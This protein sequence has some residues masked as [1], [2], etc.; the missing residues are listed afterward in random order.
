MSDPAEGCDREQSRID[1]E[2]AEWHVRLGELPLSPDE[3]I[4]LAEWLARD[5]RHVQAFETIKQVKACALDLEHLMHRVQSIDVAPI[6]SQHEVVSRRTPRKALLGMAATAAAFVLV[7]E[8]FAALNRQAPTPLPL[9]Y[10]TGTGETRTIRLDDGSKVTL[11]GQSEV[12]VEFS[13]T[14]RKLR[15]LKGE[16]FFDVVH[17]PGRVFVVEAGEAIIRDIGT[18]FDVNR[19]GVDV[20]VAVLEGAVEVRPATTKTTEA[21]ATVVRAGQKVEAVSRKEPNAARVTVLEPVKIVN[22]ATV[23]SWRSGRLVYEDASLADFVADV[24]RYY[25]PGISVSSEAA[26]IRLTASLRTSEISTFLPSLANML[27]VTVK[28]TAGGGLR[29]DVV[30]KRAENISPVK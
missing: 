28:K 5:D 19:A 30:T 15:L 4:G 9:Q 29:I 7:V 1:L 18:K 12:Q 22:E 10:E 21:P 6:I 24:S 20:Q 17:L 3:E 23:V 27:P 11:G 16:A 13:S 2:A 14:E 25:A 8:F 26:D